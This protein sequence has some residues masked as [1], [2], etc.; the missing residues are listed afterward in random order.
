[1]Q[2][3]SP[4]KLKARKWT[5][6]AE[7][8]GHVLRQQIIDRRMHQSN[9]NDMRRSA[10]ALTS[11]IIKAQKLPLFPTHHKLPFQNQRLKTQPM[12]LKYAR[13]TYLQRKESSGSSSRNV[14][15]FEEP[16]AESRVAQFQESR[17]R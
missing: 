8:I 11:S 10:M 5:E 3:E 7:D 15:D 13:Q 16:H 4:A 2:K 9:P 14:F 12:T 6:I 17:K 1:M